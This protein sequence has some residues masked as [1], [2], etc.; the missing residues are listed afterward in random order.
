MIFNLFLT[1]D[2]H[3][4]KSVNI[5]LSD[6]GIQTRIVEDITIF[7]PP[8]EVTEIHIHR[9]EEVEHN[10]HKLVIV[11]KGQIISIPLYRCEQYT[12]C[13]FVKYILYIYM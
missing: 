3:V 8:R 7:D 2:G 1:E 5:R 9:S 6:G 4:L 13:R 12:S 10:Q 11:S